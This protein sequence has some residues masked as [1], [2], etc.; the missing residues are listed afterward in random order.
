VFEDDVLL[1]E[2]ALIELLL[3]LEVDRLDP[4]VEDA[5]RLVDEGEDDDL[6]L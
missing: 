1:C 2:A 6:L 3:T 5:D 4:L